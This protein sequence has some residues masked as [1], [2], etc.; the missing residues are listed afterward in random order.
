MNYF[1][2]TSDRQSSIVLNLYQQF[3]HQA[4]AVPD[5]IAVAHG[6]VMITYREL[7]D[8]S[9]ALA[10]EINN[11]AVTSNILGVSAS[12]GVYTIVSLLAILKSG[13]AY[14]P[15]DP[16]YP[17]ERLRQII[18]ESGI[19]HCIAR[20]V[21]NAL[22]TDLG[23]R[24]INSDEK[25]P[26]ATPL[27]IALE[28]PLTYVLFTSGSTGKPKG[29][30][31]AGNA[32]VNLLQWQQRY[33]ASAPGFKTLQYA[34]LTFDVSFQEIFATLTTGGTLVL[35]DDETRLDPQRLLHYTDEQQINRIFLPFVALQYLTAAA[36]DLLPRSL[37]EVM[38]A[39][40][41]LKITEQIVAFFKALRGCKL[42]NQYG[43]TESH[44]VTQ[45]ELTGD[46]E[47][48]PALPDIGVAIDHTEIL[49]LDE[50]LKPVAN[51][52][53]GE[54]C[55]SGV[56]LA[57]GYLNRPDL[58]AEKFIGYTSPQG[59]TKRI[60]RT[61]DL[62]R[63][64][65]NGNIEYLGR[66]DNQVK[67]RGNRVE[68]GEIEVVINKLDFVKQAVV[69]AREYG[70]GQKRLIAY[71]VA[72]GAEQNTQAVKKQAADN[73]PDYMVPSAFIWLDEFPQT[74][75]GKVD[76]KALPAPI[77][78][79][80]ELNTLYQAPSNQTQKR[81]AGLWADLL[82]YDK[83]GIHDNFFDLGG[84]SL[85]AI[86]T[87]SALRSQFGYT[88]PVTRV[89]QSPTV[90]GIAAYIDGEQQ[91][92]V[93]PTQRK[94]NDAGDIAIIAMA[95]RFPGARNVAEFWELLKQ[96]KEGVSFF[97][98]AEL[99]E[100]IPDSLK[101]NSLYVKARGVLDTP[102]ALDTAFFNLAPRMAELMD[103]QQRLFMEIAWEVL[104][105]AG[106]PPAQ[107][108]DGIGVWAG[109]ANNSYYY[110]NILTNP[111]A[112]EQAGAFQVM[113]M[114]EKDYIATRT[115]YELNLK[116]PAVSVYSACSTS[117]LAV[118]QA[119]DALRN[120]YC[121]MALAG[122]VTITSPVKSGHLY[123][124]GAMLS[125]D[126][127]TRT[128]D[129]SA[130]GTVFSDSAGIVLLKPLEDALND[131]DTIYALIKGTGVNND[132]SGKG[133]FTAPNAAGQAGAIASAIQ[134]ADISASD[135]SYIEAH[136]TATPL[137]DPIELEGLKLA[138]GK[139]SKNQYCAIGSV[140]SNMGHMI[141]ASGVAGLIKTALCLHHKVLVPSLFYNE[142]NP[143][144][145]FIDSPF[146]V[147]TQLRDWEST[148]KR[149]AGVS[150][151]GV[152]GTNVHVVLQDFEQDTISAVSER[153]Y[154]LLTWSAKSEYSRDAYAEALKTLDDQ[155]NLADVAYTLQIGRTEFNRR[156]FVVAANHIDL[157]ARLATPVS[158]LLV[159]TLKEKATEVAFMF[160]GQG[161]Q[162][163]GMGADLYL[164][165]P[166]FK[167]AID[168]CAELIK[169]Y[170][171]YD[172]REVIYPTDSKGDKLSNLTQT[173]YIQPAIFTIEYALAQLWQSWGVQPAALLGH[174]IGEFVAAHLAGVF[175]LEDALKMITARAKLIQDLPEGKM[176]ALRVPYQDIEKLLPEGLSI[177]VINAHNLTVVSGGP[178]LI[179]TFADALAEQNI[180]SRVLNVSHALH[181]PMMEAAIEPFKKVVLTVKLQT[182]R[183]P[184]LSGVSGNWMTDAQATSADYWARHMRETVN[185]AA[186]LKTLTED[187]DKRILLE[188]GPGN[189]TATLAKNQADVKPN[190]VTVAGL[191]QQAASAYIPVLNALGRLWL[192]GINIDWNKFYYKQGRRKIAAP[193]YVFDRKNYWIKPGKV[194]QTT[195][196][197]PTPI[198]ALAQT[199]ESPV[200][201]IIMR[202]IV[203]ANKIREIFEG[204]SGIPMSQIPVDMSFA[205][206]G[207]D[208]LL[209]TQIAMNLKKEFGV[210]ITFRKLYE[211]YSTVSLLAQFLDESL[212]ADKFQ[213]I[214]SNG[215]PA[216]APALTQLPVSGNGSSHLD[217]ITQQL[218]LLAQQVALLQNSNGTLQTQVNGVAH[219]VPMQVTPQPSPNGITAE[220][221]VEIKKPFGATAR[222]DRQTTDLTDDK[223]DYLNNLTKRYNAKTGKSKAYTQQHRNGMADPRVVSGFRP[224]TK[225]MVYPLVVNRSKGSHVW[226]L[227]GNDYIDALN[228]FGSNFLGYN[229]DFLKEAFQKQLEAGYEIGPQH[230]LA[231]EVCQLINEFTGFERSA[232]CNTGSEAVLG[233]MRMSRT[234][235]G[236]S[237]IVAF[238]GSYHGINDEV[239]VRG[240]KVLK[241]VPAAPGIMP[242]VVQNMLILDYGTDE[243]LEIIRQRAHELAAVLVEPV[244]SRRPEFQP[245]AFLKELRTITKASGT[246]LIF[247]E[248]ITGFRMHPGGAQAIF[249]IRADI[250]TYG[251]V[252]GGGMPIGV[253]AGVP[254]F[255]DALDGG[256]WQYG[257]GSVPEA[258]VTYFAGTF[259]RHPLALA[260]AKACLDYLKLK[261]LAL[262][263]GVNAKVKR[264]ADALNATC[265]KYHLPLYIANFGS[266]W[267]IK[268]K[269][270]LAYGELLFTLMRYRNIHIWDIFPCFL[271]EAHT[272]AEIDAIIN[273]FNESVEELMV[274][275]FLPSE[276]PEPEA[277]DKLDPFNSPPEPGARLGRD[278]DGHPA[279]F[280][281]NPDVPGK[282]LQIETKP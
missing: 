236:R 203:L 174:S 136:G 125:R 259:V 139:Q 228:G 85:L 10:I 196:T 247:D 108:G 31:M 5:A 120:G 173:Y 109:S 80:P 115:A 152:G 167:N 273:A 23:L 197:L 59:Q 208:S 162:Y 3:E 204:A 73:L 155:D 210:Q 153:P 51:G 224:A 154:Q 250:G 65:E 111:E 177:G 127:H 264:L 200:Q 202:E 232:L 34:P 193:T 48:W 183:L 86:N 209:L 61:G 206:A 68:P 41:Q 187:N 238:A 241:T 30:C 140:K 199:Q 21:E 11:A 190:L 255:M 146:K 123:N 76:R 271:T 248:V 239:L 100:N 150:S 60:Y 103:P 135:I 175:S 216:V 128:F 268:F 237:L 133:S 78:N 226:D 17:A 229:M 184:I 25:Y 138:F 217:L 221:M 119:V 39:G 185:F 245:V 188:V 102:G 181:S 178:A 18:A 70:G 218:N 63:V 180:P 142:A 1:S 277:S 117:L 79:R 212:P 280:V 74:S 105:T 253:I 52:T 176:L 244:Q 6:D 46:P 222:I 72:M 215:K 189:V 106:Y 107:Y 258:G 279:W 260:G 214:H 50:E 98:D 93:L 69:V 88:V 83:I 246:A 54:L 198:P 156:R 191:D 234:V 275:G 223:Q 56:C 22:F 47:L 148:G 141:A 282:Y 130:T 114:N 165:E 265:I 84:N 40:E 251:K 8:L 37:Q 256:T 137:G 170:A 143:A 94:K 92:L 112:V 151:F 43:P 57:Q 270:E 110:N 77:I 252:I 161:A 145:N 254:E 9:D 160:P 14:L 267:K 186:T 28:N 87:V 53:Q 171:G 82:Q 36:D 281:P 26:Q 134:D 67:I 149:N 116:G 179:T 249:D 207:F 163:V 147:N 104:E 33:S 192:H 261:G 159:N 71:L 97:T 12:R 276:T 227:D 32:L 113:T 172:I 220:E 49:I 168:E 58:T 13:K 45:L 205:E 272:D 157:K 89:Y 144:I 131:G 129:S 263:Q 235:T 7:N 44:V 91:Q 158:P 4:Q 20:S 169:Q 211:E 19:T 121:K 231:G 29:V 64:M 99:D 274:A 118:S 262:Q 81:L 166:V 269:Y 122:G 213:P 75:S 240:T 126:G 90:A 233:A 242:E 24:A 62:A 230:E 95:G 164:H 2:D 55:I 96:G 42:F 124:E 182:P 219:H 132:G 66:I 15:L 38:T 194:A 278:E 243:S 16:S 266:L 201:H 257:D 35:V 195:P 101:N 225:E 27:K